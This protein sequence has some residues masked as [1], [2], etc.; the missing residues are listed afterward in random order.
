MKRALLFILTIAMVFTMIPTV[1]ATEPEADADAEPE[2]Q[3]SQPVKGPGSHV[4]TYVHTK[5]ACTMIA[6]MYTDA[7]RLIG[8]GTSPVP[9]NSADVAIS[10]ELQ[11]YLPQPD[12]FVLRAFLVD[13]NSVPLTKAGVDY[14]HSRAQKNFDART[15]SDFG[16]NTVLDFDDTSNGGNFAV[17]SAGVLELRQENGDF[18]TL[19]PNED[20]SQFT[21]TVPSTLAK[22]VKTGDRVIL[23]DDSGNTYPLKVAHVSGS[24]PLIFTVSEDVSFADFFLYIKMDME[25]DSA[26][27]TLQTM[28]G[29]E[30][31]PK[32]RASTG[33]DT[34]GSVSLSL[35]FPLNDNVFLTGTTTFSYRIQ[36]KLEY[37][38]LDFTDYYIKVEIG[39]SKTESRSISISGELECS[40]DKLRLAILA[41]PLGPTGATF[42]V[43]LVLPLT[44]ELGGELALEGTSSE[45]IRVRYDSIN[46]F[47][48]SWDPPGFPDASIAVKASLTLSVGIRLD[49]SLRFLGDFFVIAFRPEIGIS[50]TGTLSKSATT[51]D[52]RHLC[53]VCVAG[54]I[55]PYIKV[56]F[57]QEMRVSLKEKK[58]LF[59]RSATLKMT[60]EEFHCTLQPDNSMKFD[61]GE[62]ENWGYL[63]EL[64]ITDA[65]TGYPLTNAEANLYQK[66]LSGSSHGKYADTLA[67]REG[68]YTIVAQCDGYQPKATDAAIS[69]AGQ[70]ELSLYPLNVSDPDQPDAVG[71]HYKSYNTGTG[72]FYFVYI[73][74]TGILQWQKPTG[75][76]E[77]GTL[78]YSP[79]SG[80]RQLLNPQSIHFTCSDSPNLEYA[81]LAAIDGLVLSNG[82]FADCPKLTTVTN[83]NLAVSIGECAF[84]NC[85]LR[86]HLDLRKA[87]TIGT[88]AFQ[89]NHNLQSVSLGNTIVGQ[90]AFHSCSSLSHVDLGGTTSIGWEAF[91]GC[92]SLK[93]ITVPRSVT[94][95]DVK[96]FLNCTGLETVHLNAAIEEIPWKAFENCT[97]LQTVTLSD[98][99]TKLGWNAF[100][101]AGLET[102]TVPNH[103][104]FID[105]ECFLN[106]TKLTSVSIPTSVTT[107]KQDAF[108]GC[109]SLTDISYGGTVAQW[110][111]LIKENWNNYT[112]QGVTVHCADGNWRADA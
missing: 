107:I 84:E 45:S 85:D 66:E 41:M 77:T 63:V 104:T 24:D 82:C 106:C 40:T 60:A 89:N 38:R 54:T 76:E 69:S 88:G 108:K 61:W 10:A 56:A 65:T 92:I 55:E 98:T 71:P 26:Q 93:E 27:S 2:Y 1:W 23:S 28:E 31:L 101:G 78:F 50:C 112:L 83:L 30:V 75:I 100:S 4:V 18:K 35:K 13:G 90:N 34:S 47:D 33:S 86:G 57:V 22:S 62:C 87:T 97:N 20:Q 96:T 59:Q 43:D 74:G 103:V 21:L 73:G 81:E 111:T 64:N 72:Y 7:G 102:F 52:R 29:V 25:V 99:I 105:G 95:M 39:Y 67:L 8:V 3:I 42:N 44:A 37:S 48:H 6:A 9:A 79:P 80:L 53:D 15:E 11:L 19:T 49:I 12:T 110:D 51:T 17:L 46:G 32:A 68:D 16:E 58:T 70:L 91:H 14:S 109:I 5:D 36:T 94:A